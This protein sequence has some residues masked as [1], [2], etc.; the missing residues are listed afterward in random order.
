LKDSARLGRSLLANAQA[1]DSLGDHDKAAEYYERSLKLAEN[2]GDTPTV[3]R[4]LNSLGGDHYEKGEYASATDSYERALALSEKSSFNFGIILSLSTLAK[5][6]YSQ[7]DYTKALELAESAALLARGAGF[8]ERLWHALVPAGRAYRALARPA[9][10]RAAFDE[11][12]T[13]IEAIRSDLAEGEQEQ[14]H[15]LEERLSPYYEMVGLLAAQNDKGEALAYA[16]RAKARVLL[17]VLR[18]GRIDVTN[19]MSG[20]EREQ[21]RRLNSRM[22]SLNAQISREGS[23]SHPEPSRLTDL[24]AALQNARLDHEAFQA[25]LYAAHQ[26]L[27]AKRGQAQPIRLEEAAGLLTDSDTALLEYAVGDESTYL[28]ALT[29]NTKEG[30]QQLDFKVYD[31]PIKQKDLAEL[32]ESFRKSLAARDLSFRGS[33]QRL[34]D[35]LL[36][37]ARAQLQGKA[38]L[39]IVPDGGL[40]QLPFQA[41]LS[42]P[43]RYLI[44]DY[45][46]FYAP[47]LTVLRE[48]VKPGR[49]GTDSAMSLLAVG[50]PALGKETIERA[51]SA[52]RDEKLDPLPDAEKE[53]TTLGKLY[54][55]RST[56]Y[57]GAEAREAR[58]KAEAGKYDILHL[59]THGILNDASPMYSH[60][61]LSQTAEGQT[62]DGLLEAWEIMNLDLKAKL[63]VLSACE[64]ARG[65]VSAGE[66]VIGLTWALFV[67]GCPTT[68]VSQWKMDSAATTELM[69]EFHRN[70]RRRMGGQNSRLG[71]ASSLR[72]AE[73][74]LLRTKQYHHPFYWAGFVVVGDGF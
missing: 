24:K 31:I 42:A 55:P 12:I 14:Q 54:A 10:A 64:T 44:Q 46:V 9:E 70:L 43:N 4:A 59:A 7:G 25:S 68:V 8:R 57:I 2:A 69:I 47:S 61:V 66:G 22:V 37:P 13:T 26:E 39:L 58:I 17:D 33:A 27:R 48:M 38:T 45:T 30:R 23:R 50:N 65:R 53:A 41:L 32:A 5:V 49:T 29:K 21:E 52:N 62:E 40:W 71:V 60:L 34:Y 35:L 72:E 3:V 28:F 67:A 16:E 36:K 63:V 6:R 20:E 18:S 51:R 1:Y 11:C 74:K 56:V 19:T 73:L 15:F